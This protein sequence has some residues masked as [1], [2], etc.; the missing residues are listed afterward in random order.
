[1]ESRSN[2]F[3]WSLF[4]FPSV[5]LW[6]SGILKEGLVWLGL[7]LS[8]YYFF[9][10]IN[11]PA[12]SSKT[13][14]AY[15]LYLLIGFIILYEAKAYVLLCIFPCLA[16]QFFIKT[17]KYCKAHPIITYLIF[18]L[19]YTGSSFLPLILF[20]SM[21]PLQMISDKQ[22]DFNRTSKGG[23][24]MEDIRFGNMKHGNVLALISVADSINIVPCSSQADSLLHTKGIQYLASNPVVYK[25]WTTDTKIPFRLKKGT[26]YSRIT[27]GSTDTLHL[28]AS[29]K[30]V[31]W[32]YIYTETANSRVFIEPLKPELHS[33]LKA[34]PRALEISLLLPWPSQIHSIMQAIYCAE[35][36][37]VLFLFFIA[38]FFLK[39]PGANI[40]LV[41]FC[42]FYSLMM[43]I[44]I[45]LVSPVL[46]GI[47]RYKSVVIPF[48]F[49]LLLLITKK[50]ERLNLLLKS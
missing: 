30:A 12:V 23:I 28:K 49:I 48:M 5:V 34:I 19:L 47:E 40:D 16:A 14:I 31:Y 37:F 24:Y 1:V 22:T 21:N 27:I 44:L 46:G 45:G 35:N 29:G 18:V 20:H 38:L 42:F 43:L 39:R 2:I 9:R 17:V 33:L 36:T 4:L 25:E 7:G 8:V 41:L 3:F 15:I 6:S 50:S 13:R 10:L 26:P 11:T 32:V